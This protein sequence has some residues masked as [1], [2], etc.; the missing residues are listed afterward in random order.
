VDLRPGQM[1]AIEV[2]ERPGKQFSGRVARTADALDA[3][4]RTLL[5]EVQVDN[6]SGEL[7]PG[8]YASVKFA[9]TRP[10]PAIVAPGN[11]LVVN[12]QG[13]RV[14]VLEGDGR[15]H[16]VPVQ[17]GRDLGSEVEILTGLK[18]S[19]QLITNPPDTLGEGQRVE[20]QSA[21]QTRP[22]GESKS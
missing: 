9:L 4:S 19:E 1:A 7:L 12:S 10:R 11:A 18:G 15:A 14:V 13:T 20:V 17:V 3:G 2:R 21:P 22:A 6:A 16:Y 5:S 8:M